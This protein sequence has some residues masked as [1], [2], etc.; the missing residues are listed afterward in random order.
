MMNIN[1]H[2]KMIQQVADALGLALCK[3]M[4]FVGGCT[5]GLMLPDDF[6]K[7][8]VRH[9]DDVDLIIHV[10]NYPSYLTLKQELSERGFK[11]VLEHNDPHL[12]H[13]IGRVAC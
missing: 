1:T 9:T 12:C 5:T 2:R 7:E 13:A 8:Q 4:A 6:T 10:V 3:Q 11:E